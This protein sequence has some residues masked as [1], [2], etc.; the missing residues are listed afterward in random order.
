MTQQT[1]ELTA[2]WD[3]GATPAVWAELDRYRRVLAAVQRELAQSVEKRDMLAADEPANPFEHDNELTWT[4]G[5][6]AGLTYA[7]TLL[8]DGVPS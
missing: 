2:E 5:K 4:G 3:R 8:T 6:I 7:L 1:Q